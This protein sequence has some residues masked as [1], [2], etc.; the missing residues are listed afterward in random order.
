M[1]FFEIHTRHIP[2]FNRLLMSSILLLDEFRFTLVAYF[3]LGFVALSVVLIYKL[4]KENFD[5]VWIIIPIGIL[6]FNSLQQYTFLWALGGS[7]QT[8]SLISLVSMVYLLNK[9]DI[10][11]KRFSLALFSVF[12]CMFSNAIGLFTWP[13]GLLSLLN[14]KYRK[15]A[16]IWIINGFLLTMIF[17]FLLISNTSE[18]HGV[19]NIVKQH[20]LDDLF[21]Y[22]LASIA[23]PFRLIFSSFHFVYGFLSTILFLSLTILTLRNR[24]DLERK[25]PWIQIGCF[26]FI[27]TIITT[28]LQADTWNE[29]PVKLGEWYITLITLIHIGNIGLFYIYGKKWIKNLTHAKKRRMILLFYFV[30]IFMILVLIPSYYVGWKNA[31]G[32]YD[33]YVKNKE[34]F[35]NPALENQY[36]DKNVPETIA[37]YGDKEIFD[38]LVREKLNIFSL[39]PK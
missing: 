6:L 22:F 28:F 1:I 21:L 17:S 33:I 10:S 18:I 39:N 12:V 38:F 34:C 24:D 37:R 19:D 20:D 5:D 8:L 3:Q 26:G 27:F 9:K 2:L 4:V 30:Y 25:V 36:C 14:K 11:S 35:D 15:Y 31:S 13:L 7:A 32:T 16:I 23:L 29:N